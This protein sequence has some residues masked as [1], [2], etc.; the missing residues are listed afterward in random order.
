MTARGWRRVAATVAVAAATVV[1]AGCGDGDPQT[2]LDGGGTESHRVASLWWLMFGLAAA[3][4]IVVGGLVVVAILRGRRTGDPDTESEGNGFIWTGGIAMPVVILAVLG[5]VTV[6]TT[7][8]VRQED[9][10]E[11]RVDVAGE[12]WWWDVDYPDAGVRTA[13]EVHVPVGTVVDVELRSDNVIHSFW[14][15]ALAG[16]VDL[17]PG[18]T[19]HLRFTAREPGT[20]RGRCAEFCGLQ[21][22]HMDFVVIAQPRQDFDRWL[23][24][25]TSGAGVTPTDEAAAQGQRVFE[26][27]ACAGCHQIA[28]TE[29]DGTQ[30]PDLTDFG[31]R[32]RIGAGVLDNTPDDLRRWITDPQGVKPGNLM[33]RVPLSDEEVDE[34]VAYLESLG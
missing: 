7:R 2:I 18:Q 30:G 29:A 9:P 20:Y 1:L 5:V 10:G 8:A 27:E 32:Q 34:I 12:Q 31:T 23:A 13:N 16:K 15:P 11:L 21:H 22:A 26:R 19:N 33:P 24:R 3:V 14:V 17:I 6:T 25:R 28:G 4:Y